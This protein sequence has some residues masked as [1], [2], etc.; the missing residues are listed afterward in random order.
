MTLSPG[1]LGITLLGAALIRFVNVAV[2]AQWDTDAVNT[3]AAGCRGCNIVL[4][5]NNTALLVENSYWLWVEDSSF[6]FYPLYPYPVAPGTFPREYWG[7]RPSVIL[8]G[9]APV[10]KDGISTVYL[11]YFSRVIFEGGAVQYQ[12]VHKADQWPGFFDFL[13]C[14]TENSATPL[15]DVQARQGWHG[16]STLSLT[17]TMAIPWGFTE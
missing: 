5:S 13:Y 2:H 8:R 11:V 14:Q 17:V 3:S 4:G 7:Q 1:E 15:L 12:Q 16:H 10:Y 6:F 9:N